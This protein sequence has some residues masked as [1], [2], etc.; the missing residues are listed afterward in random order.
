MLLS[1]VLPCFNEEPVLEETHRRLVNVL[2]QI[3]LEREIVYV[4]DGSTDKTLLLLQQLQNSDP[5]VKVIRLSRN[6]GHQIAITAGLDNASGDAVVIIDSDLQDPP[7]VIKEMVA[8]WQEGYEVVYGQRTARDGETAFRNWS[9]KWFSRFL[10]RLSDPGVPPDVGDFRLLD[11][12]VVQALNRMP[13]PDRFLRGMISWLGFRQVALPYHREA[14]FAG[15][16]KYPLGK[17]LDL[18]GNGI[19]SFSLFPSLLL[20]IAALTGVLG[21]GLALAGFCYALIGHLFSAARITGWHLLFLAL[22]FLGGVQLIC[23]GLVGEYASRTYY[24]SKRRPNY[25]IAE[26]LGFREQAQPPSR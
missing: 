9:A 13:E 11:R 23:L 17:L 8:L 26:R 12:K 16:S 5:Q 1:V 22:L 21:A 7:E 3:D 19:F 2:N 24:A 10:N 18:A 4:D 25:V 6:Y 14:R 20:R 15:V